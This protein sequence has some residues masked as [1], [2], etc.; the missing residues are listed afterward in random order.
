MSQIFWLRAETKENEFRRAI[1][2]HDAQKMI[3]AGHK[4]IVEDW[5]ESIIPTSEYSSIG[6]EIVSS[7]SWKQAPK[8]AIIVGLKALPE[9]IESFQHT[10]IY[11]AHAYKQQEGYQELLSKFIKGGGKIIDLEYMID[12]NQRRVCAFGYWAGYVG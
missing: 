5:N 11:F 1:T 8:E 6:C 9:D 10:H 7:G 4:V 2:P 12:E 3:Q